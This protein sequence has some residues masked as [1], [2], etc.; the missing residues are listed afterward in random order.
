MPD[1]H[2]RAR[3]WREAKGWSRT[4]LSARL[5]LSV[6]TIQD[7]EAGHHANG[8]AVDPA[9]FNRY[10]LACAALE[11]GHQAWNWTVGLAP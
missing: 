7:M 1:N 8:R 2:A 5:T 11:H 3:A 6:S 10:R 9:N 4:E